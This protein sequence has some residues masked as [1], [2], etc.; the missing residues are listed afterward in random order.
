M[1]LNL[2]KT[3]VAAE[4]YTLALEIYQELGLGNTESAGAVH[5]DLGL[6]EWNRSRSSPLPCSR[7]LTFQ[8]L[9]IKLPNPKMC[10]KT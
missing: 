9:G 1:L 3:D 2:G 5:S 7:I 6:V 8:A 4:H 10:T